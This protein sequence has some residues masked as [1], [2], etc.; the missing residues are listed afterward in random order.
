[1]RA[2]LTSALAAVL[3]LGLGSAQAVEEV[4]VPSY[5]WSFDGIF[6]HYD[7]ANLQRGFQVH[8]EVCAACHGLEYVAFRNLAALGYN[9]AEV[10]AIAAQYMIQDGPDDQGEMFEREGLPS[11]YFPSPFP[12]DKAAAAAN[13]GAVPPDLSLMAKARPGGPD[14]IQALLVGYEEPP[15]DFELLEGLHYNEYFPGHQIAMP[16]P[17]TEG[18]V[19]FADGTAATVGQ[20][21]H[22]VSAFLMW[23]A[24]PKMEQ[25]KQTGIKVVVFLIVLT[26]LIYAVKRRVWAD[27]H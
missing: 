1:M 27:V 2:P 8:K 22:D 23:T 10:E 26:G 9:G 17:L 7:Q 19:E 13:G 16:P 24:E 5:D 25:R 21:A 18:G 15:P 6:G 4:E 11:D 14:Y 20:M 3:A 12:N